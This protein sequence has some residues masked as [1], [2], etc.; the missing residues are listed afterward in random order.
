MLPHLTNLKL[1]RGFTLIELLVVIAIIALLAAILFPVFARARENARKSSCA[2]NLK[3]INLGWAQYTQDYDEQIVPYSL[4]GGSTTQAVAWTSA[5]M[6]YL[7]SRQVYVCPS[8]TGK[9]LS[10]AYN[11][12]MGGAGRS[13]ADIPLPTKSPNFADALGTNTAAR[14]LAFI[15]PTGAQPFH[16]GRRCDENNLAAN[17]TGSTEGM[18]KGDIHLD[19]ANYAFAD[20]HVKWM[21]CIRDTVNS[22][23]YANGP[24]KDGL[25]YNCDGVV[26][27]VGGIWN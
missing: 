3:Q 10:Y 27:P 4:G 22:A 9:V 18:I 1:R 25:D 7:K 14:C 20:G 19:G 6:P 2:N 16:D 26:G 23:Q 11:F 21:H 15:L 13:L 12:P 17:W 8:S 24:P 5:L